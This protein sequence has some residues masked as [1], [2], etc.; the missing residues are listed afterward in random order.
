MLSL[1][2]YEKIEDDFLYPADTMIKKTA[3]LY[4]L[5]YEELL[6]VGEES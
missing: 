6:A 1:S 3:K 4:E 2:T 5:T